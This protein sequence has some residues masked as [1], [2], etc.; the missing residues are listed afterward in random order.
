MVMKGP[1]VV[2]PERI[3]PNY[4]KPIWGKIKCTNEQGSVC[5]DPVYPKIYS[6]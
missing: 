1:R 6:M 3:R 5:S 2:V 4:I